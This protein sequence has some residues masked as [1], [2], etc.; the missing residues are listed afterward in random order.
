M[1]A[2]M[3]LYGYKE[4]GGVYI[5]YIIIIL[6]VYNDIYIY[7]MIIVVYMKPIICIQR[8]TDIYKSL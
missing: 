1:Y 2:Y 7:A 3:R 8:D 6:F 5:M 4:C